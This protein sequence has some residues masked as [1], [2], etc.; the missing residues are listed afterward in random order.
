MCAWKCVVTRVCVCVICVWFNPD[1]H[2]V[3]WTWQG[4]R[5]SVREGGCVC[6]C[7]CPEQGSTFLMKTELY[8]LKKILL[9]R[10]SV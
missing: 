10:E 8:T 2:G 5:D 7:V 9:L 1:P 4:E 6:V 3:M